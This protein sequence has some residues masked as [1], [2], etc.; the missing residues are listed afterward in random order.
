MYRYCNPY[1][2]GHCWI[3]NTHSIILI[4]NS[5]FYLVDQ[6]DP[7]AGAAGLHFNQVLAR[8]G[9]PVIILNLV[10]VLTVTWSHQKT[11]D[12]QLQLLY[13]Y[14]YNHTLNCRGGRE[15]D[16]RVYWLMSIKLLCPISI[17]FYHRNTGSD[18]WVLT[19]HISVKGTRIFFNLMW[20]NYI[21]LLIFVNIFISD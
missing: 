12:S 17:S 2:A 18:T 6:S 7:Y 13:V 8:Y 21:F 5:S 1:C 16:M 10:K 19:W 15:G 4:T 3:L 20:F 11:I 14:C 9:S